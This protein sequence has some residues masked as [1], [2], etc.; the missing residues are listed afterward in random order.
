[1]TQKIFD[2]D[3]AEDMNLLWSILPDDVVE[4]TS[5][6]KIWITQDAMYFNI[7]AF[8]IDWHDKTKITRPIEEATGADIG[9]LCKFCDK[10]EQNNYGVLEEM[11]KIN[12]EL[13]FWKNNTGYEHCRRLTKQE[14]EELC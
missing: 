14:I 8:N 9:K 3:N 10:E 6:T 12:D 1:M 2:T 7:S 4:L 13:R 11:T 5:A